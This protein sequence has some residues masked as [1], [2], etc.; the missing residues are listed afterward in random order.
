MI[1]LWV[2]VINVATFFVYKRIRDDAFDV[3]DK[4]D[5]QRDIDE[6][7]AKYNK[8]KLAE[9]AIDK[10]AEDYFKQITKDIYVR[11]AISI[12]GRKIYEY[13]VDGEWKYVNPRYI[14]FCQDYMK[15]LDPISSYMRIYP[16]STI[17]GATEGSKRLMENPL[18]KALIN[19]EYDKQTRV[20]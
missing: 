4:D 17:D 6:E 18:I 13:R 2:F 15:T 5:K 8:D 20:D 16:H 10:T 19:M 1:I 9:F 14:I 3:F 11:Y 12:N 7:V